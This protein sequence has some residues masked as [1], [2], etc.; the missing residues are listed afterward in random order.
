MG[1]RGERGEGGWLT[2][3]C[4]DLICLPDVRGNEEG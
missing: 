2:G 3:L 1:E 4:G